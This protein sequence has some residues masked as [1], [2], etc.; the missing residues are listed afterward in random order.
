MSLGPRCSTYITVEVDDLI[1]L[2]ILVLSK[3]DSSKS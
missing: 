3:H 2:D 1:K